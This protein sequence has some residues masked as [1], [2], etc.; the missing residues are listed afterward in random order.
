MLEILLLYKVLWTCHK[1]RSVYLEIR[2]ECEGFGSYLFS[3]RLASR[4]SGLTVA[5]GLGRAIN[6]VFVG[7]RLV[8]FLTVV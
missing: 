8:V 1:L 6:R 5:F 7:L 2:V 4:N 3:S